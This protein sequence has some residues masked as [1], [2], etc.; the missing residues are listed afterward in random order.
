MLGHRRID[1][2]TVIEA[3]LGVDLTNVGDFSR[4]SV[5]A[6]IQAGYDEA[7][8]QGVTRPLSRTSGPAQTLSRNPAAKSATR[9]RPA[10]RAR[11]EPT[12]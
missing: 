5:D 8:R 3:K 10:A 7:K 1:S 9:R 2:F 4:F 11:P 6:R 12:S